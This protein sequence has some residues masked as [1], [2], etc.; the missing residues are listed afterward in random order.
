M[1]NVMNDESKAC[2]VSSDPGLMHNFCEVTGTDMIL[3]LQFS[4]FK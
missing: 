3:K 2:E 1:W 4:V